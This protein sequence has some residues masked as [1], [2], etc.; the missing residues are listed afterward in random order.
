MAKRGTLK[1]CLRSEGDPPYKVRF[2]NGP[3]HVPQLGID[4]F[5]NYVQNL[6]HKLGISCKF[7]IYSR[8]S[9]KFFNRYLGNP[10]TFLQTFWEI[11]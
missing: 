4:H 10:I 8:N 5:G 9:T 6:L 3:S 7:F 1:F 2:V 11:P